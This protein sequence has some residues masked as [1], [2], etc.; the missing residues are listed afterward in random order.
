MDNE[1]ALSNISAALPRSSVWRLK[2]VLCAWFL[3]QMIGFNQIPTAH[4]QAYVHGGSGH[5]WTPES[6]QALWQLGG[7]IAHE[8]TH[9]WGAGYAWGVGQQWYGVGSA[10][11]T[12]GDLAY[13][14]LQ[15]GSVGIGSV[16][17]FATGGRIPAA[18][19]RLP[20]P[21][22][23]WESPGMASFDHS[24]KMN[25]YEATYWQHAYNTVTFGIPALIAGV[26][27]DFDKG[28]NNTMQALG[29]FFFG[30]A[31]G[32]AVGAALRPVQVALRPYILGAYLDLVRPVV[33]ARPRPAFVKPYIRVSLP[34]IA[35]LAEPIE[36]NCG[37]AMRF[38]EAKPYR[39]INA[40]TPAEREIV[41]L[42]CDRVG[43]RFPQIP[44]RPGKNLS[45]DD[46]FWEIMAGG[47]KPIR[48]AE[49]FE[50][51]T[52]ACKTG[53]WLL[54]YYTKN[55]ELFD[56]NRSPGK[57][58]YHFAYHPVKDLILLHYFKECGVC[59][60]IRR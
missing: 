11:Y 52:K 45:A 20:N 56:P 12:I 31:L 43:E 4:G 21:G 14:G 37:R 49:F 17:D 16:A 48:S 35:V 59:G 58:E 26:A 25:G 55:T 44:Q 7:N 33:G 41:Q 57:L 51:E 19:L 29:G 18:N 6:G 24:C 34:V 36:A 54:K 13:G 10:A 38:T 22:P 2:G 39:Y 40:I 42:I 8:F 30:Y 27:E 23:S 60:D 3:S 1:R 53:W 47:K 50:Q 46:G 9:D 5:Y 32:P 28:T 15:I